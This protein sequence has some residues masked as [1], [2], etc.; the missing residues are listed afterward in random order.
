MFKEHG[1]INKEEYYT[2]YHVLLMED[3]SYDDAIARVLS[4]MGLPLRNEKGDRLTS[5][6]SGQ[7]TPDGKGWKL[8]LDIPNRYL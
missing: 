7:R 5:G 1:Y 3:I 2:T 6:S 8:T 4:D